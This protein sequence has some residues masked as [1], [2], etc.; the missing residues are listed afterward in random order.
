MPSELRRENRERANPDQHRD[1]KP[2]IAS[3]TP[4]EKITEREVAV[5]D[6]LAPHPRTDGQG[7]HEAAE[8]RGRVPPPGANPVT[9][10]EARG[11]DRRSGADVA[12]EERREDQGGSKRA[13]GDEEVAARAH[14][15]PDPHSEARHR[16]RIDEEEDE[17]YAHRRSRTAG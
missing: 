6:G 9:E 10:G 11:T 16:Q 14:V 13:P 17:R 2:Q 5:R 7:E 1:R 4:F 15:S 8:P 3:V 12:G